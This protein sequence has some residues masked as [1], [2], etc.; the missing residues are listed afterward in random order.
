MA[1]PLLQIITLTVITIRFAGLLMFRDLLADPPAIL[2]PTGFIIRHFIKI[3]QEFNKTNNLTETI[4]TIISSMEIHQCLTGLTMRSIKLTL[5]PQDKSLEEIKIQEI[6]FSTVL[7]ILTI[8]ITFPLLFL[9]QQK[10]IEATSMLKGWEDLARD[11]FKGIHGLVTITHK[12]KIIT[13]MIQTLEIFILH[14][15]IYLCHHLLMHIHQAFHP[16]II[17]KIDD[18]SYLDQTS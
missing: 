8:L 4:A 13:F 9:R 16:H 10:T 15:L 1:D 14:H 6:P 17:Y 2:G 18:H 3:L 12:L 5:F 11:L 7:I